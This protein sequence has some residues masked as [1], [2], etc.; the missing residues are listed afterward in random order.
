LDDSNDDDYIEEKVNKDGTHTK[1][2]V[3]NNG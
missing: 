3:H 2:E 1:K